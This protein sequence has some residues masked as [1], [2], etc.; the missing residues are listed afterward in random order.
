MT[1]S[2]RAKISDDGW[3][4]V[5]THSRACETAMSL[6][7]SI[8]ECA[9]YE[10]SPDV[11]S[12]RKMIEG[13]VTSSTPIA[14]RFFSP[15]ESPLTYSLPTNVSAHVESRRLSSISS[16][17]P[18]LLARGSARG[19]RRYAEKRS[20][21]RGVVKGSNASCCITYATWLRK[22]T[23][24]TSCPSTSTRPVI[25]LVRSDATRPARMLSSDVLPAPDGPMIATTSPLLMTPD[26]DLRI[27]REPAL[28]ERFS[29]ERVGPFPAPRAVRGMSS[30]TSVDGAAGIT[31][32]A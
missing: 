20:A 14:V 2:K 26:I 23:G 7:I 4:I 1:L 22:P 21:S 9:P 13:S 32:F 12:S 5:H 8:V 16:T 11:G 27:S 28:N 15:P 6:S 19:R 31:T 3:W 30:A 10:S 24:S 18:S 25:V 29:N 17:I